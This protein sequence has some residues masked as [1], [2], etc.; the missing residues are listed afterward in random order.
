MSYSLTELTDKVCK[1]KNLTGKD[2]PQERLVRDW[3]TRVLGHTI[4]RGNRRPYDDQIYCELLLLLELKERTRLNL[5]DI[6]RIVRSLP[7][8]VVERVAKGQERLEI[9]E[10]GDPDTY[11]RYLRGQIRPEPGEMA[12]AFREGST[13]YFPDEPRTKYRHRSETNESEPEPSI[14][15]LANRHTW[16]EFKTCDGARLQVKGPVSIAKRRQLEKVAELVKVIVETP[17]KNT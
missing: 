3:V 4:G 7:A 2:K 14:S 12:V 13:E 1:N 8:D 11:A 5:L 10:L 17:D 16:I 15:S 6:G 9:P